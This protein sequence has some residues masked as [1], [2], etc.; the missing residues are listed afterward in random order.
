M[1]TYATVI[2]NI[3]HSMI[4]DVSEVLKSVTNFHNISVA[5][6]IM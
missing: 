2:L 1:T 5:H 6:I 3:V 4:T